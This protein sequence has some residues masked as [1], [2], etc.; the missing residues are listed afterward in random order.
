MMVWFVPVVRI[1]W[2][3]AAGEMWYE[4]IC[5]IMVAL[6]EAISRLEKASLLGAKTCDPV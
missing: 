2:L 4:R 5:W 3:Q 1:D 6:I